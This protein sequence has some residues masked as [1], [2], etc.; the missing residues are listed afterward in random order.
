VDGGSAKK[1]VITG[2]SG[3]NAP[4]LVA[5][6]IA[7]MDSQS[8]DAGG[9]GALQN[10]SATIN[11]TKPTSQANYNG[12]GNYQTASSFQAVEQ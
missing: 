1:L 7:G 8:F 10:G 4:G 5:V 9:A 11:L 12:S 6:L 3:V 2:I